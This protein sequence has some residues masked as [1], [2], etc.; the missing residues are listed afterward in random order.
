MMEEKDC[1]VNKMMK[2]YCWMF[3]V[4]TNKIMMIKKQN[5]MN[6]VM[7]MQ[8]IIQNVESVSMIEKL[9]LKV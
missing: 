1:L 3:I 8:E 7:H 4:V 2:M 9:L 6:E 5:I